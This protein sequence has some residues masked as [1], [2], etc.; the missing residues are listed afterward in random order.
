MPLKRLLAV[1][2]ADIGDLILTTP[3]LA[4]L[5][6][7]YP[8]A[9]IDVLTTAHAA[10]VLDNTGLAD[11]VILFNKFSFDRPADLLRP[12]NL[13]EVCRLANRFQSPPSAP[14]PIF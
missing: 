4:A 14:V 3:A 2:L 7:T 1:E 10:P 6:E 8:T 9:E 5:R 12:A 13:P 11:R